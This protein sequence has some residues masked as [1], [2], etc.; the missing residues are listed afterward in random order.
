M[1]STDPLV[2][3]RRIGST[4]GMKTKEETTI[5]EFDHKWE[6]LYFRRR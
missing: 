5:A 3:I 1:E 2:T 4:I 6:L